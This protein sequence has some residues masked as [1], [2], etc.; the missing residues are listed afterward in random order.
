MEQLHAIVVRAE[1]ILSGTELMRQGQAVTKTDVQQC[2]EQWCAELRAR[3]THTSVSA[4]ERGCLTHFLHV[5]NNL[6]SRLFTCYEQ[7]GLP[8]TNNDLE[9]FI[10]NVKTRYRRISGRKN[11][12]RYLLRYG[13]RVA[14]YEARVRTNELNTMMA[15]MRRVLPVDW[16]RYRAEQVTRQQEQLK[17][18]RVRHRP[19]AYLAN[20]E[21]R[22][23]NLHTRT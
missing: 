17:Q 23:A 15:A 21:Q 12:N 9:G 19:N 18:H 20:L 6:T 3:L 22:W 2:Y 1:L 8:R 5:T 16:R 7:A 11:W 4:V 14:F 13:A 10:R